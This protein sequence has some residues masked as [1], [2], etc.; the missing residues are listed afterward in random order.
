MTIRPGFEEIPLDLSRV[1]S[2]EQGLADAAVRYQAFTKLATS[3]LGAGEEKVLLLSHLPLMSFINRS[4]SLHAGITAAVE[5]ANPHV[6]FTLL[7]AYSELVVLTYYVNDHPDYLVALERPMS[8]L[9]K[10][11]RK[12]F[13]ELFDYAAPE[14]PGIR[15]VY[16]VLSEMAHFGS[17]ALWHPFTITDAEVEGMGGHF[18]Y[19]TAPHWHN[20]ARDPLTGLAMLQEADEAVL[21]ILG[22]FAREHILLRVGA[23][24]SDGPPA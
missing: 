16:A 12:T 17:T 3:S 6:V 4:V 9:P 18:S 7:R 24:T 22:A 2:V 5:A 1:P 19:S 8:D 20:P 15:T 14:M 10:G 13:A 23:L 21:H 11:T